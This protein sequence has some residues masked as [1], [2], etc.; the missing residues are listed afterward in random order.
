MTGP[1]LPLWVETLGHPADTAP[2]TFLLL[3]GFGGSSF[4]WRTWTPYL[5]ERGHVVLVDLKGFGK[6][7]KPDDDHYTPGD[8]ATYVVRLIEE[9]SL[10]GITLVGHSLG[11]G[12]A[13]AVALALQR[14]RKSA[15]LRRLVI[16]AGAAY[17]QRLPPFVALARHPR[18]SSTAMR[19]LGA[20]TVVAQALRAIVFDTTTITGDQIRGYAAPLGSKESTRALLRAALQI[21]P[22]DLDDM[23]SRY[24]GLDVATLL[25]WGRHDPAVPLWVGRR[26][27]ADLPRSTLRVLERCG[28]LPAEE[29]PSLSL[30][31]LADFL[32]EPLRA[33]PS[34]ST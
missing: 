28:H 25:L 27:H 2:E 18:L 31:V 7:P 11:G 22:P 20:R 34:P 21:V 33:R 5:A 23:T 14:E 8:Q 32:E 13:L 6:A 30:R 4:S 12:I 19:L 3:H 9:R 24:P 29:L 17:A 10:S 16:V 15:L 1:D 26:L